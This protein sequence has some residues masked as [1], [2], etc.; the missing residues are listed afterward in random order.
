MEI[1]VM[2]AI[3]EDN[4]N[5]AMSLRDLF[6]EKGVLVLNLISSPGSGKTTLLEKTISRLKDTYSIAV[7]EGDITTSRDAE[8]LKQFRIPQVVINTDGA[9]HLNSVSIEKAIE[10]FDLDATDILFVENVGNLVCPSEF[11]IG[12]H[13]KIALLSTTEGDDKPAKYPLLFQEAEL[14]I[15]NKTDL[16]PY[17]NFDK[18]LFYRDLKNINPKLPVLEVSASKGEGL[19]GWYEWIEKKLRDTEVTK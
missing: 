9:C 18:D 8:R 3:M 1:Q 6:R 19:S 15:L 13:A 5:R 2:R 12:E 11:D 10:E 16:I 14:V 17:T 7:I 4:T